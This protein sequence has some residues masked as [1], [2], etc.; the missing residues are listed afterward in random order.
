MPFFARF[1]FFIVID[2]TL[3]GVLS[4]DTIIVKIFAILMTNLIDPLSKSDLTDSVDLKIYQ[5]TE[6]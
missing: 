2:T 4:L 5:F 3:G 1:V 6:V